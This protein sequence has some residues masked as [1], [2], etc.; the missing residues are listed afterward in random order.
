MPTIKLPALLRILIVT[1]LLLAT[2]CAT[3]GKVDTKQQN[4]WEPLTTRNRQNPIVNSKS[5]NVFGDRQYSQSLVELFTLGTDAYRAGDINKA[6][7]YFRQVLRKQPRHSRATYN[8]SMI[9]LQRA[10]E[11]L[12]HFTRLETSNAQRKVALEMIRRLDGFSSSN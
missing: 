2:G 1:T 5:L 4:R 12:Q 9:Y 7:D 6:E 8:L 3:T 11:G 10:Y